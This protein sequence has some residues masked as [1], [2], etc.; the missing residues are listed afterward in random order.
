MNQMILKNLNILITGGGKG[1][2]YST[3][4]NS[5]KEGAFVYTIIKSKSDLPKFKK[6]S[7]NQIS[8]YVGNITDEKL[9]I[10]I[11]KDS[12]KYKRKISG[13]VNNAGQRQR[14]K[15]NKITKKELLEIF[16]INFFSAFRIMQIFTNY[17]L[18]NKIKGSIVNIGS[19]VGQTGFKDLSG[20]ASTKS[21]L[22]GLTKSY[23]TEFA[24]LKIRANIINPGFT[25]TSYFNK[26]KKNKSLYKWTLGRIPQERWGET[27]E[28]SNLI[29]FLLS[30]KSSYITGES[31]NIDGGWLSS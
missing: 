15:F 8:I 9:I 3:I 30:N 28:I 21:A 2:G 13:L 29:C 17:L 22:A 31:I 7:K 27:N 19:I 20:Y 23:S 25:K 1:I 4:I 18:T 10:K 16:N 5:I 12:I 6:Y 14:I 24:K 26:F 11:F